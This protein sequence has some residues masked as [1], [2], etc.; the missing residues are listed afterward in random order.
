[1]RILRNL[2][3][4][5]DIIL[6]EGQTVLK[7]YDSLKFYLN[8]IANGKV[9]DFKAN[10]QIKLLKKDPE[11]SAQINQVGTM[12]E[13]NKKK[14]KKTAR[15]N[16]SSDSNSYL[17]S[18]EGNDYLDLVSLARVLFQSKTDPSLVVSNNNAVQASIYSEMQRPGNDM[19]EVNDLIDRQPRRPNYDGGNKH[20]DWATNHQTY[21]LGAV[22]GKSGIQKRFNEKTQ[23]ELFKKQFMQSD[24]LKKSVVPDISFNVVEFL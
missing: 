17:D 18:D 8:K 24:Q 6:D 14:M 11:I 23:R 21:K 2:D 10:Q 20:S 9:Y 15:E 1:M 19:L 13:K 12:M 4:A 16:S 3:L 5:V 22:R 7:K